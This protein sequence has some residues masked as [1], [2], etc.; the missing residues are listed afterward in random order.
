VLFV[1]HVAFFPTETET[2]DRLFHVWGCRVSVD[3]TPISIRCWNGSPFTGLFN[4]ASGSD[5]STGA[6]TRHD[7]GPV[8]A[9]HLGSATN[10]DFAP[11]AATSHIATGTAGTTA[12]GPDFAHKTA[13]V[14]LLVAYL[15]AKITFPIV[16]ADAVIRSA[17]FDTAG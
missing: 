14:D 10:G 6:I 2:L 11:F 7:A 12:S 15:E 4:P 9:V 1:V 8:V 5:D 17:V 16:R 13:V 3:A